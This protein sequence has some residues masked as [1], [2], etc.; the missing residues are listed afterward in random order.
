MKVNDRYLSLFFLCWAFLYSPFAVMPVFPQ[1]KKGEAVDLTASGIRVGQQVP[2]LEVFNLHNYKDGDGRKVSSLHLSS[3]KGK[4][5]ILDFWATWCAPCVGMMPVMDSLQRRFAGKVQFISVTRE[6]DNVVGPFFERLKRR[7]KGLIPYATSD[8]VLAK[9]FPH[10]LLPHYV[11]IGA[12]GKVA[13]ITSHEEVNAE[14]IEQ[15]VSGVI[16]SGTVQKNDLAVRYDRKKPLFFDGNGGN[17][18]R[19]IFHSILSGWGDGL[20]MSYQID[21]LL[22]KASVINLGVQEMYA[23][24]FSE[25]MLIAKHRMV[26][27][28][29]DPGKVRFN[30][31]KDAAKDWMRENMYCYELILPEGRERELRSYMRRD[32]EELFPD[33]EADTVRM[34]TMCTVLV[35]TGDNSVLRS[36]GGISGV[37]INGLG[38][39]FK[40]MWI[41]SFTGR[42]DVLYMQ[43]NPYPVVDGSGIGFPIDLE[44][45]CNMASVKEVNA[46][47]EKYNLKLVDKPFKTLMLVFRDAKKI[48]GRSSV[49][50]R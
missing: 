41:S 17:A 27:D 9:A 40:N 38:A 4:L 22:R 33:V 25:K 3:L 5:V 16:G 8:V 23:A 19:L 21:P 45:E 20:P 39:S 48:A 31:G 14:R 37:D 47:L 32:L 44:L 11:W 29:K 18:Q 15:M 24:V 46:A 13:A 6:G 1:S 35:S 42:L 10:R 26:F 2:D 7:G 36:K 43:G 30:K 12:D 49:G 28:M 50:A 34:E